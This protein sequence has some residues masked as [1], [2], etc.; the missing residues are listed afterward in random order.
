[1]A[2]MQTQL[3]AILTDPE[4]MQK[5]SAMAQSL[6]LGAPPETPPESPPPMPEIDMATLQ[7]LSGLAAG[8]AIDKDQ[9]TLLSALRPYLTPERIGKLEKAMRAARLAGVATSVLGNTSL[10]SGR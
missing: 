6:G 8:S 5:I 7:K 10:F 9:R 2:D 4:M 3:N 1:M